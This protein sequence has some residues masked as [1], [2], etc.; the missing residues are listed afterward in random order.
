MSKPT[1]LIVFIFLFLCG[2]CAAGC[3][4]QQSLQDNSTSKNSANLASA[5]ST[6]SANENMPVVVQVVSDSD[7]KNP[8]Q[9]DINVNDS[10]S[11]INAPAQKSGTETATPRKSRSHS[12]GQ[13]GDQVAAN[14]NSNNQANKETAAQDL[15]SSDESAA[16]VQSGEKTLANT[17]SRSEA[18]VFQESVHDGEISRSS[19]RVENGKVS[20]SGDV[21]SQETE[22]GITKI[23]FKDGSEAEASYKK[24]G[25]TESVSS[26]V[27]TG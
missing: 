7:I 19:V 26:S 18:T 9:S 1:K 11:M 10:G 14:D 23:K 20:V 16:A 5:V 2:F 4:E 24:T 8:V 27:S 22:D 13:A 17:E 6:D 12:S 15:S 25:D 21:E 3:T